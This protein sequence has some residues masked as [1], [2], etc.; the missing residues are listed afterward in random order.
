MSVWPTTRSVVN[1]K[2]L[3]RDGSSEK[4]PPTHQFDKAFRR[5]RLLQQA[6]DLL[7]LLRAGEERGV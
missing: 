1:T 4:R 5:A 7:L 3:M 2:T 6:S